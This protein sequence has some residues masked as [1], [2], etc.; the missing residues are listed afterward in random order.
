MCYDQV[1]LPQ[2]LFSKSTR[3]GVIEE[4]QILTWQ[5]NKDLPLAVGAIIQSIG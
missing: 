2:L 1:N 3:L 5:E 4:E